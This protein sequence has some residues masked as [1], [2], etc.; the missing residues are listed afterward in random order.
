MWGHYEQQEGVGS[1]DRSPRL[2]WQVRGTQSRAD[3][4]E[5]RLREFSIGM[6]RR[7]R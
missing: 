3:E 7:D 1:K 4:D 5:S 2:T 6:I